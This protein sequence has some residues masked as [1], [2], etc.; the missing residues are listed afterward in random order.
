MG[1]AFEEINCKIYAGGKRYLIQ[2]FINAHLNK[3]FNRFNLLTIL[4]KR[5]IKL[6]L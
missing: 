5:E 6:W 4:Q 1:F 2:H 3:F